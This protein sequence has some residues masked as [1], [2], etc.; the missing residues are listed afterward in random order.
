M[1]D[2]APC[3][4][5]GRPY[6]RPTH[7]SSPHRVTT[8]LLCSFTGKAATQPAHLRARLRPLCPSYPLLLFCLFSSSCENVASFTPGKRP[9]L[10]ESSAILVS[11][12]YRR[13]TTVPFRQLTPR[14]IAP[15]EQPTAVPLPAAQRRQVQFTWSVNA[16]FPCNPVE[17]DAASRRYRSRVHRS[18]L[19]STSHVYTSRL[20]RRRTAP[21]RRSPASSQ[22]ASLW[23][24]SSCRP[25]LTRKP[26]TDIGSPVSQHSPHLQFGRGGPFVPR[27]IAGSQPRT[28]ISTVSL[29]Y[30]ASSSGQKYRPPAHHEHGKVIRCAPC[31]AQRLQHHDA[32]PAP[33]AL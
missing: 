9:S 29:P 7:S 32:H 21:S 8:G 23:G 19:S 31:A 22:T 4:Q 27:G 30:L 25:P 3:P 33:P 18:P 5:T 15:P 11:K 6:K 10:L 12:H 24:A 26:E 20:V 2:Q 1:T 17:K 28:I 16:S 13:L 14:P